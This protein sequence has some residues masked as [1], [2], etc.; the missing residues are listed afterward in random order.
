MRTPPMVAARGANDLQTGLPR[1]IFRI[2]SFPTTG[3]WLVAGI[4]NGRHGVRSGY[5][6]VGRFEA[7]LIMHFS[8][9]RLAFDRLDLELGA[10]ADAVSSQ[11][12]RLILGF[13][14]LRD[15]VRQRRA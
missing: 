9:G 2:L 10:T 14:G 13:L 5:P 12:A 1:W 4:S 15:R 7:R 8:R 3:G 6:T 11:G